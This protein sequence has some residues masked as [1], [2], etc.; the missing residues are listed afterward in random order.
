MI[1][2][3]S[4]YFCLCAIFHI[5]A[6][7]TVFFHSSVP[8][9]S[10]VRAMDSICV[11]I[12]SDKNNCEILGLDVT[13]DGRI[14]VADIQNPTVKMFDQERQYMTSYVVSWQ[15]IFFFIAVVNNEE[16]TV[17]LSHEK[18]HLIL[19][20]KSNKMPVRQII[21]LKEPVVSI[22][23]YQDKI[24]ALSFNGSSSFLTEKEISSGSK[25]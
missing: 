15:Y 1:V 22:S 3:W 25:T 19:E 16:L 20:L 4:S 5:I 7:Y 14:I 8:T 10:D 24:I 17:S 9:L 6:P 13:P 11:R 2:F 18:Q 21:R 12:P 23:T